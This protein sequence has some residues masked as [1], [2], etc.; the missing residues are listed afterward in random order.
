MPPTDRLA[1]GDTVTTASYEAVTRSSNANPAL[2]T[3]Y[4]AVIIL[5]V[6][7]GKSGEWAFFSHN[8]APVSAFIKTAPFAATSTFKGER[9]LRKEGKIQQHRTTLL[10]PSNILHSTPRT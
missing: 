9:A 5:V 2:S 6:L 10:I 8:T 4:N 3:A 7:A 1:L